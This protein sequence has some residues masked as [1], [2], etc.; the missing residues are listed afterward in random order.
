MSVISP[1]EVEALLRFDDATIV[2]PPAPPGQATTVNFTATTR[3][4]G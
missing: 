2:Q 3:P 1:G 4:A